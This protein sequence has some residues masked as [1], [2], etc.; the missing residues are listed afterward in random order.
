MTESTISIFE[1]QTIIVFTLS[2]AL[3][4]PLVVQYISIG[5]SASQDSLIQIGTAKQ[6][7]T[8]INSYTA[9]A[10]FAVDGYREY[11]CA[12]TEPEDYPFW[13][14]DLGQIY[15]IYHVIITVTEDYDA[16]KSLSNFQWWFNLVTLAVIGL[17]CHALAEHKT[18]TIALFTQMHI[19]LSEEQ[20][21]AL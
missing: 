16:G 17:K 13:V 7:S 6:S 3:R 21:L 4:H 9:N 15:K 14:V 12:Q 20:D 8:K 2:C 11:D 1:I 19:K 5:I 18:W 10:N